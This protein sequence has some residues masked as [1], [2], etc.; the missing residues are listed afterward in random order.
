[1]FNTFSTV[2]GAALVLGLFQV[3]ALSDE[4]K[5]LT[6]AAY[7]AGVLSREIDLTKKMGGNPDTRDKEQLL[8]QK[9]AFLEG[10]LRLQKIDTSTTNKL[11]EIGHADAQSC[12]NVIEKCTI[13]A[14]KRA[15]QNMDVDLSKRLLDNCTRSVE[16]V[17][18]RTEACR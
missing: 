9:I 2:S 17:C 15:E 1:M 5:D 10:A 13:E 6:S 16:A 14:T 18:T 8:A 7:C 3:S 11:V 4:Y 12:W